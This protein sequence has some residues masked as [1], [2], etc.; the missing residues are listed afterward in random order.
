MQTAYQKVWGEI[1]KE[2]TQPSKA[3]KF[4]NVEYAKFAADVLAAKPEFVEQ[5]VKSIYAGDIY[6]LKN[7][8]SKQFML[9]LKDKAFKLMQSTP[10]SFHKV[11]EGC[12]DFHRIID[13]ETAKNYTFKSVRHSS[14]YFPWN[15]DPLQMREEVMKRWRIC[16]LVSGRFADEWENNTPKDGVVDRMQVAQYP[17]EIGQSETH[18]DPIS[19]QKIFISAF[20]SKRGEDYQKGGFYVL[21]EDG[22]FIDT[23][24]MFEIG[25]MCIGYASVVHGV[26]II[27]PD[28]KCDWTKPD[29]RWWLGLYSISSNE[30]PE[31]KRATGFAVQVPQV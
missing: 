20:M 29:G 13:T 5:V 25:D 6:I 15:N 8:F 27:D 17:T 26:A 24:D 9:G 30:M 21:G 12:P 1:E 23:E 10:S 3:R 19:N 28:K 18:S 11:L 7:A 14:F 31:S 4:I 16:K 22:K 2:S